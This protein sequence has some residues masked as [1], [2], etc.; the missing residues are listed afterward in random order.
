MKTTQILLT[1]WIR[2]PSDGSSLYDQMVAAVGEAPFESSEMEDVRDMQWIAS[3]TND[4]L[5]KADRLKPFCVD[6]AL[7][8]LKATAYHAGGSVDSTTIKDNRADLKS[9]RSG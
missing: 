3:S 5:A 1:A 4:A 2:V 7:I 9:R 8:L 6:P